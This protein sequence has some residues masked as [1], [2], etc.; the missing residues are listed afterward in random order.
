MKGKRISTS[1]PASALGYAISFLLLVGLITSGVLFTASVN[2]RLEINYEINEHLLFD[3]YL[4]LQYGARI[5]ETGSKQLIHPGGDTS[6][7][8]SKNWGVYRVVV[9]SSHH[10]NNEVLRTALVGYRDIIKG[11]ALYLSDHNKK[12]VV[13]GDTKVEGKVMIPK[14]G[15]DRGYIAGKNYRGQELIYGSI[16]Q[17]DRYLPSINLD[18]SAFELQSYMKDA[19]RL[20]SC[21]K[22]SSFSFLDKTNVFSAIEPIYLRNNLEGNL[23]IH[24]FDS[25]FIASE[26]KL[27]HVI[28]IA[29]VIHFEKGFVGCVQAIAE[30]R[31]TCDE[32]VQLNYPSALVV[33]EKE[34][35]NS[36]ANGIYLKENDLVLGG[37]LLYSERPDSRKA[38]LLDIQKATIGGLVYNVGETEIQGTIIGSLY[39]NELTLHAG[40]GGYSGYLLDATISSEKLPDDFATPRWIKSEDEPEPILLACF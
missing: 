7:I 32:M 6:E 16:G 13:C 38:M 39:T 35:A 11:P 8:M 29:P 34:H 18:Q 26:S 33:S 25:I 21:E 20:E 14:R 17:S 30:K 5:N 3:N 19:T 40:G 28:L 4:S 2:K 23:L 27:N 31:I 37:V 22:D 10:N 1:I 9:A 15:V 24:S 12:L 36:L